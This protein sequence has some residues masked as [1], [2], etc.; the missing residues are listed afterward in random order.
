M[1]KAD[2]STCSDNSSTLDGNNNE[3]RLL[4]LIKNLELEL[5]YHAMA[6]RKAEQMIQLLQRDNSVLK[7]EN[8]A[9]V[10]KCSK[11]ELSIVQY[12]NKLSLLKTVSL[13]NIKI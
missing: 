9:L 13:K 8:E 12:E 4:Q 7:Q 5:G 1:E 2:L 10:N 6:L 11:L 3:T